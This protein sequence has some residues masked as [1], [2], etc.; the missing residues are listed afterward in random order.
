MNLKT[1]NPCSSSKFPLSVLLHLK[2]EK[3]IR[4][5]KLFQVLAHNNMGLSGIKKI[6]TFSSLWAPRLEHFSRKGL[7]SP[8]SR[9]DPSPYI[10]RFSA[11]HAPEVQGTHREDMATL[12]KRKFL[13][14]FIIHMC[15]IKLFRMMGGQWLENLGKYLHLLTST[16]HVWPFV[17]FKKFVKM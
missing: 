3:L 16:D 10:P 5:C 7:E 8:A 1:K 6:N 2:E 9:W 17:L 13:Y 15:R 11:P 14:F 4:A 12:K